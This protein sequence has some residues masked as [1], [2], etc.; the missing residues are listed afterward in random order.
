MNDNI[1]IFDLMAASLFQTLYEAFP[2]CET[3]IPERIVKELGK[4]LDRFEISFD[5]KTTILSET[6]FWLGANGF[7]SFA[8]PKERP[9]IP[10]SI[11]QFDCVELTLKGLS[12]M[13]SPLPRTVATGRTT[14]DEIIDKFKSGLVS[15]A[16][17]IAAKAILSFA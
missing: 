12:L 16:G 3:V 14:G 4:D 17:R 5:E 8:Y 15:E 9:E 13:K 11:T 6:L 10:T 7:I 2:K 1:V